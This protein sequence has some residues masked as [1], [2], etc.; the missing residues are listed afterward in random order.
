MN[1]Q[2][3]LGNT[4]LHYANNLPV[5]AALIEAGASLK[6]KN[7]LGETP[8]RNSYVTKDKDFLSF[9]DYMKSKTI[10]D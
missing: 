5:V 1:A 10:T 8:A 6:A 2:D 4:P 9:I 7:N 3:L